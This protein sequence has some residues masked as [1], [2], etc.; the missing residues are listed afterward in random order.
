MIESEMKR[1]MNC[2]LQALVWI[3]TDYVV[4]FDTKCLSVQLSF[5]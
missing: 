1:C 2:H 3:F 4:M 5:S